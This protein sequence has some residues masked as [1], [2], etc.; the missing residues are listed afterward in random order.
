MLS[1][2]R[3]TTASVAAEPQA[4]DT[5]PP[6]F[7]PEALLESVARGAITPLRGRWVVELRARGGTL[8]RR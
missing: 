3:G 7:G 4:A 5:K 1:L 6:H 8:S 2:R